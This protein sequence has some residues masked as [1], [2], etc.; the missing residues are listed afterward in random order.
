MN[1]FS[2]LLAAC[3]GACSPL[4][5]DE[6]RVVPQIPATPASNTHYPTNKSPLA[7]S[8]LVELPI[9]SIVPEGW[10]KTQLRLEADGMGGHL[11]EISPF[12]KFAD[13]GWVTPAGKGGWEELPYFL[14]GYGDLGYVLNDDRIIKDAR[15]WIEGILALQSADG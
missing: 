8:P 12:L 10:L 2:F 11:A 13:N 5:A 1:H 6:A 15:H 4:L 14:K 7:P 3:V 9:G